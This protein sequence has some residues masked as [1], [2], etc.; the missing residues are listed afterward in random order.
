MSEPFTIGMACAL[1]MRAGSMKKMGWPLLSSKIIFIVEP[2]L[3]VPELISGGLVVS[4]F[5]YCRRASLEVNL[6]NQ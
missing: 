1:L 6:L 2:L 3:I 5:D 4:F